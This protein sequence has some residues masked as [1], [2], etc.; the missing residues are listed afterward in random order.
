MAPTTERVQVQGQARPRDHETRT[1]L[2]PPSIL[3]NLEPFADLLPYKFISPQLSEELPK[4]GRHR[5]PVADPIKSINE[6]TIRHHRQIATHASPQP[7]EHGN[8]ASVPLAIDSLEVV[9]MH[10]SPWLTPMWS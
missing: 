1:D 5:L 10:N 2:L 7:G 9:Q 3:S 4:E 8:F 6:T